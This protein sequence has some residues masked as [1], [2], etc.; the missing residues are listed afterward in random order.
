MVLVKKIP[1]FVPK[2]DET[3]MLK[4]KV[5]VT[6]VNN[7][8]DARYCAGMGVDWVAMPIGEGGLSDKAYSEIVGW[9]SGPRVAGSS[10]QLP[11][12]GYAIDGFLSANA[13][14]VRKYA[15]VGMLLLQFEADMSF[16]AL[17]AQ[18]QSCAQAAAFVLQSNTRTL[19][20]ATLQGLSALAKQYPLF[21]GF[22]L[23]SSNI[24]NV[25]NAVQPEGIALEAGKEEKVGFNDFEAL[26][27]VLEA[28]E[29]I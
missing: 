26:A 17:A 7:L 19:D 1:N 27:D 9:I 8:H 25:L 24:E 13:E 20:E 29:E 3:T 15:G 21:L 14:A 16:E 18:C 4:T 5:I 28:L 11:S 22:G 10:A 2:L 12:E 23:S 6:N